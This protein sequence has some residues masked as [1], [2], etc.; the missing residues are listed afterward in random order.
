MLEDEFVYKF[1]LK[2]RL[3]PICISV[4]PI[5]PVLYAPPVYFQAEIV[6]KLITILQKD[7]E[8]FPRR[9]VIKLLTK[10]LQADTLSNHT[11][12]IQSA[13]NDAI[14]DLDW[15]VKLSVLQFWQQVISDKLTDGSCSVPAY[16]AGLSVANKRVE[17]KDGMALLEEICEMGGW[18]CLLV[19]IRDYDQSVRHKACS[20]LVEVKFHC[21]QVILSNQDSTEPPRKQHCP[22][23]AAARNF[24]VVTDLTIPDSIH[25]SPKMNEQSDVWDQDTLNIA[26][27]GQFLHFLESVNLDRLAAETSESTDD[28]VRNPMSLLDDILISLGKDDDENAVDCY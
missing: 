9:C 3:R 10:W 23:L 24:N 5:Q 16:A 8:A 28:Y 15:E 2:L 21:K 27:T 11:K 22:S 26:T 20:I 17:H 7:T 1:F 13:V 19:G 6:Q 12:M 18:K 14:H 25:A 4:Y